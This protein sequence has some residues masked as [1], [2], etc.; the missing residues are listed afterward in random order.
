MAGKNTAVFGI[1]K[2]SSLAELA[3]DRVIAIWLFQQRIF[4][5][6]AR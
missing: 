2:N 5:G 1:C 4:V 3:V 6:A